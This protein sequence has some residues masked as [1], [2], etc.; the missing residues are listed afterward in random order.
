MSIGQIIQNVA[1]GSAVFLGITYI[2]GGAIVNLNLT[3]RGIVEYQI[4]KVK[5]LA[6]GMI[7]LFHFI[8]V[9]ALASVP[10]LIIFVYTRDLFLIQIISIFSMLGALVL[11]Y[12]WSR[13]PP[14]TKSIVGK[15]RFWAAL[16]SVTLLF[17]LTI[18]FYRIFTPQRGGE[19]LFLNL[20]AV[21]MSA[22]AILAQI[23]HYSTFYYGRPAGLGAMDPIGMGIPTRVNLLCDEK[24]SPALAELGLPIQNNVICDVYLIDETDVHYIIGK[25]QI[26]GEDENNETYK[27]DKALVK[28]ILHKPDHMRKLTGGIGD[29]HRKRKETKA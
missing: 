5:Y 7:F 8:G 1:T 19:W 29:K 17:P 16:A 28:V 6:V 21:V 2:I 12:V 3:R 18:L 14:N 27:I 4:L 15:W 26:P 9:V 20:L 13:Y 23:Y 11:L 10:A 24:V 22:L 25:V